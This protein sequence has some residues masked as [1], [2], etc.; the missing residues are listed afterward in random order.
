M[1]IRQAESASETEQLAPGENPRAV[2]GNNE[3]PLEERIGME[4]REQLL[5]DRPQFE[6]KLEDMII[7]ADR[8]EITDDETLGKA[9]DLAKL[10]RAATSHIND[11][12]TLVK[13]PYLDG[14]RAVDAEKKRLLNRLDGPKAKVSQK[15]DAFVAEREAKRK[16]EEARIAAEQQRKA[17]EAAQAERERLAAE[18]T[19]DV[20]EAEI[21]EAVQRVEAAALAPAET[22]KAEPV[23]SDAGAYVSTRKVWNSKVTDYELAFMQVSDDEKVREAIDKAV[24]RR[25]NAGSRKIEGVTI[26]DTQQAISR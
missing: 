17:E 21:E 1:G 15:M 10:Y 8:V 16:A 18:A 4:F 26:W 25:V 22:K 5:Q 3:P 12:H 11:T 19:E 24:Q 2:I 14:G 7:A 9:G 20:S 23:R 13:K 6:Q